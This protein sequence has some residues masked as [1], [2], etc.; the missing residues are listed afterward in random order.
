MFLQIEIT[1]RCQ[2][3]C[4]YCAGRHMPQED[5]SF[6]RFVNIIDAFRKQYG[7]P[8]WVS[9]QGE[10]EPTLHPQFFEMLAYLKPVKTMTITNG[11]YHHPEHLVGLIDR[12]GVSIDTLDENLSASYGRHNVQRTLSFIEN[13]CSHMPITIMTVDYGQD[14]TKLKQY[15]EDHRF[16]WAIQKLQTKKDYTKNYTKLPI[17]DLNDTHRQVFRCGYLKT[18]IMRFFNVEGVEMPCCF[19]KDVSD[20]NSIETLH[21][22]LGSVVIPSLCEGC[23]FA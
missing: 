17:V 5:M 6:D 7:E 11:T 21:A 12:I 2:F 22:S 10:G 18:P 14:M 15:I 13:L 9:L 16:G 20:F 19:I 4:D 1:T 23:K 3:T 8:T